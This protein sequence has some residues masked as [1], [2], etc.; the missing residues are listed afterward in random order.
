M[1]E[2]LG[3]VLV[4]GGI[5]VGVFLW[6][7]LWRKLGEPSEKDLRDPKFMSHAEYLQLPHWR[8]QRCA[9]LDPQTATIC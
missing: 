9:V 1:A 8:A 4:L 7:V 2:F 5:G 3:F 6:G